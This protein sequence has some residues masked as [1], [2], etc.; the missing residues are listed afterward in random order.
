[1]GFDLPEIYVNAPFSWGPPAREMTVD[2]VPVRLYQKTDP[3]PPSDWLEVMAAR[4]ERAREARQFTVVK[5]ENRV[6]ALRNVHAKERRNFGPER[7]FTK[8]PQNPRNNFTK[9]TKRNLTLLPDTIRVPTDVRI[10]AEFTQAELAKMQNLQDVPT[11]ADISIHN[12]PP[13]Y[14]NNMDTASCKASIRLDEESAARQE[15]VRSNTLEDTV[16]RDILKK[17]T[18]GTHPIIVTTDEVLALIMTCSR[19]V[20]PWH[21][22]F[23]RYGRIVFI[24]KAEN[25]NIEMQWVGETADSSRRP[26][27]NDPIESER[28]TSLGVESTKANNAFVAQACTKS[29]YQMKCEKNPFPNTQPRMYRYRRYV[30]H[31][32]SEDRYDL[33]VRCEVDAV[34]NDKYLR[35]FGL[36]EQ[37]TDGVSSEWR[38]TLDAQGAKWTSD[39]YRRNA[40]K[41]ARWVSLCHLSGALMKIGFVSRCLKSNGTLDPTKHE[42]LATHTKDP[43]PLAAQLGIK[44][45]N[46]WAIADAIIL[47]FLK[48]QEFKDAEL[49][50]KSG[51]NSILLIG[52]TGDDDDDD[53]DDGDDDDDDDDDD[54]DD[55]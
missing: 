53:D 5:D 35:L 13:I 28:I 55:E 16:F 48:Q 51:E 20:H 44:I 29:R 2:G 45:A 41:M 9:K 19:S 25:S 14:N 40:Q 1:M 23:F 43:G 21:V 47:S 42:V 18:H 46:M 54:E 36:L 3:L 22:E 26:T 33:L 37:C 24:T 7:R 32:D 52:H 15:F 49:I 50:K 38:K 8:R 12:R 6:K 31:G 17:E 39:E 34:Q 10:L 30:M 4:E 11:V 27:E